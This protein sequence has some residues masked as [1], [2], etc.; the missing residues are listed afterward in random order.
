M[1][2]QWKRKDHSHSF[3]CESIQPT[4]VSLILEKKTRSPVN[5]ESLTHFID[6]NFYCSY[7]KVDLRTVSFDV[8]PQEVDNYH[9][10]YNEVKHYTSTVEHFLGLANVANVC[11]TRNA[12]LENGCRFCQEILSPSVW[13]PLFTT[14]FQI[15]QWRS[16]IISFI[17]FVI[18]KSYQDTRMTNLPEMEV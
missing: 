2:Q 13:K 16:V 6:T 11:K 7:K 9:F 17:T 15:L 10:Y 3:F 12:N 18:L 8:P 4:S 14:E 5:F 1:N